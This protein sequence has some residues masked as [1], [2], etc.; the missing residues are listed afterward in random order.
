MLSIK[1]ELKVKPLGNVNVPGVLFKDV[2]V[3]FII[4]L[5]AE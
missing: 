5:G 3:K 2:T 4:A 1:F